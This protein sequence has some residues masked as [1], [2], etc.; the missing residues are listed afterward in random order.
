MACFI[1]SIPCALCK[2]ARDLANGMLV[3][4][5]KKKEVICDYQW[6]NPVNCWKYC[7]CTKCPFFEPQDKEEYNKIKKQLQE[8]SE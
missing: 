5:E 2:Y 3:Y 1:S 6:I 8:V 4:C 7:E